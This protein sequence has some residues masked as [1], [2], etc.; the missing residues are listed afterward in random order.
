[1][2]VEGEG[3]LIKSYD[4]KKVAGNPDW[5]SIEKL[6]IDT[7]YME[8]PDTITAQAQI[9]YNDEALLV[10]LETEEAEIRAVEKGPLGAPCKD[11]CLEFFFSPMEE[12]DRYFNIEFNINGC[13]FLG[14]G[15]SLD[16]L[17]R[18]IVEN[19]EDILKPQIKKGDKGWEIYYSIPFS[20][21]RRFFPEFDAEPDKAMRAN[22]FK[23]ADF[24]NPPHYMSWN[25]IE[26]EHFTFH[27]PSSF[28][29]MYFN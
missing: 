24:S 20:F 3:M 26:S 27:T 22:C 5:S 19:I 17:T 23:C 6:N 8:T 18:L 25:P 10:H 29:V 13:L 14:F 16:D 12:D 21:I 4:I 7:R 28:G 9:C 15:S 2:V 1:M 11:S